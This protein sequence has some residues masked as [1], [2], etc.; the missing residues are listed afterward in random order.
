MKLKKYIYALG[1]GCLF[2]SGCNYLD[3]TAE[4]VI[5]EDHFWETAT[6]AAFEQYCNVYYPKLIVGH[7][8][9]L[10]WNGSK[11]LEADFQS[12]DIMSSGA[13]RVA[14]GQNTVTTSDAE[15]DWK[16]IRACNIF[17]NNYYRSPASEIDKRKYAGEMYF[18]KAFD[19]FN[20]VKRFGEVPW[21]HKP[22]TKK[23]PDIYKGRDSRVLVMDSIL[24]CI[25]MAVEFLPRKTQVYRISKD[26]ALLL[27]ARICLF[28]GTYRRYRNL[29]GD[30]E[31]LKE[32]YLAAGE[33]M[34]PEYKYKLY[35]TGATD[36][37]YFNLFIQDDYNN[38]S[39]VILSREYDPSLNMGHQVSNSIPLSENGMSRDCYEEFL[40]SKTGLPISI[41]GCHNPDMGYIDEMKNRDNRLV[42]VLCMPEKGSKYAR[43]LYRTDGSETK[44]GA[45]NIFSK[46]AGTNERPFYGASCTGYAIAKY[47]KISEH[48]NGNHKGGTDAPVMRYAEALLIRAEAAAELGL[49]P[50]LDKTINALRTR[51][52][53]PHL[54]TAAPTEDPDL[55]A[56]YP[57]IK[58][59]NPNL[60][61]EIRRERRVELFAE[62]FRWD[63]ICR[64]KVGENLLNR[65]RRGAKM[66]PKL[67]TAAEIDLIK[68]QVGFDKNGFITPYSILTT[69]KP[70]FTEKN[71]LFNI[72]LDQ[73]SLNPNLLPNNPGW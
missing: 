20:K 39:E 4:D 40:C 60:I 15:W 28:E 55:V 9:A 61:R 64:W 49:D 12:D 41:C 62:G 58:G 10:A 27:K 8:A 66:D 48:G 23:D 70:D 57:E 46:L 21:Y 72:P 32:A 59:P 52:G 2:F 14:F 7:G 37:C 53:F 6:A 38:N 56:K 71:Y 65:E 44:G 3:I 25:N 22:L 26:A 36:E 13:N 51:V 45:P 47:Y 73:T 19:Y 16:T 33:L 5:E 67:Y 50:E 42:Q 1:I 54:L 30:E 18:F 68:K 17:L 34:K 31:F 63:D 43:Y 29:E 24:Y 35:N 69:F 11:M